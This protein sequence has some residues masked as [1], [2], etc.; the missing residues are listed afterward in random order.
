[1]G[2]PVKQVLLTI[3]LFLSVSAPSGSNAETRESAATESRNLTTYFYRHADPELVP[4]I[5][6][7][8]SAESIKNRDKQPSLIGL[9]SSIFRQYPDRV[10]GWVELAN[11]RTARGVIAQALWYADRRQHALDFLKSSGFSQ[12]SVVWLGKQPS[13]PLQFRVSNADHL[14]ILWGAFFGSGDIRYVR[15]I[16]GVVQRANDNQQIDLEDVI[17]SARHV[18]GKDPRMRRL[19]EKYKILGSGVA[20]DYILGLTALWA[21]GS[22]SKQHDIIGRYVATNYI[23]NPEDPVAVALKRLAFAH[24]HPKKIISGKL[25]NVGILFA[26]APTP[27]DSEFFMNPRRRGE[28]TNI[29]NI[30]RRRMQYFA[31]QFLMVP[32]GTGLRY[33]FRLRG[34]EVTKLISSPPPIAAEA[35]DRIL[36]FTDKID[37]AHIDKPGNY[38]MTL[39]A[40]MAGGQK[41]EIAKDLL[42]Y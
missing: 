40:I 12:K 3:F 35:T 24:N 20:Q 21:L 30:L 27:V 7:Y 6:G 38:R 28:P 2:K 18:G 31:I 37:P 19:V 22:N 42:V 41:F 4:K 33:E 1:M 5:I 9:L 11:G 15:K 29:T 8:L 10:Q 32:A 14:D 17:F 16:V 23:E 36:R 25:G 26:V 39:T 34:P 13:S